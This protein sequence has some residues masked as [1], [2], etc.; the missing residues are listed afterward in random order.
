MEI[1]KIGDKEIEIKEITYM[2]ALEIED[3]RQKDLKAAVVKMMEFATNL[4]SDEISKLSI[5]D[6]IALQ[7]EVNKLNKL[8]DFQQSSTGEKQN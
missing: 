3:I 6:G 2:N 8:E 5:S 7:R 4:T 1:I